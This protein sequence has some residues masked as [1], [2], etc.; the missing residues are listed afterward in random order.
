MWRRCNEAAPATRGA[1][2]VGRRALKPPSVLPEG[3]ILP[4]GRATGQGWQEYCKVVTAGF[5]PPGSSEEGIG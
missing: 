3:S 5:K 2:D 4:Q 1:C